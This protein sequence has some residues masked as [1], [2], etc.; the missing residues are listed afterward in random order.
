MD[1]GIGE[2]SE[3]PSVDNLEQTGMEEL[4]RWY[5]T[6]VFAASDAQQYRWEERRW[7]FLRQL[8][9]ALRRPL[10]HTVFTY[11]IDAVLGDTARDVD[12]SR[13]IVPSISDTV[14]SAFGGLLF[15]GR[16]RY[17]DIV[18]A[19]ETVS[20]VHCIIVRSVGTVGVF[21]GWSSYGTLTVERGQADRECEESA[22]D[23]RRPLL[24]DEGESF[25]L[26][27]GKNATIK[28]PG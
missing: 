20:R 10:I 18:V 13:E 22:V 1:R 7:A 27:V 11:N 28:F 26:R 8:Q 16:S 5:Q 21:D 24:F 3:N 19:D 2:A 15:V 23:N 17:N 12:H 25:T 9:H 4:R 6:E 14:N